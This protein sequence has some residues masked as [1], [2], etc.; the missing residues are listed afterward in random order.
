[1]FYAYKWGGEEDGS[2]RTKHTV[3]TE[4]SR[5]STA[6]CGGKQASEPEKGVYRALFSGGCAV[7]SA[8]DAGCDLRGDEGEGAEDEFSKKGS[9]ECMACP[10]STKQRFNI[11]AFS[12]K[13]PPGRS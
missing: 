4:T 8:D 7:R 10:V 11:A 3:S 5:V 12:S 9:T 2:R 6:E 13:P 1:M